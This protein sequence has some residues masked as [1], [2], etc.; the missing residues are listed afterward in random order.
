MRLCKLILTLSKF[1]TGD[2]MG[3]DGGGM[4]FIS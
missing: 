2:R 3:E 4:G 1:C